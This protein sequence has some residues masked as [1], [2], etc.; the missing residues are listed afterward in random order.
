MI[1]YILGNRC[2]TC[3]N[4]NNTDSLICNL[5]F[6]EIKYIPELNFICESG[7]FYFDSVYSLL[8]YNY[9]LKKII[10]LYKFENIRS[11][12]SLLARLIL[13]R[14]K[15]EFFDEYD[16]IV[17]VPLHNKK[18]K[19]RGF[20]QTIKILQE[21]IENERIFTDIF[22]IR[23]TLQQSLLN[24]KKERKE[25]LKNI[26]EIKENRIKH[27]R[28]KKILLF[29]DIFTTGATL[30]AMAKPFFYSMV[31]KIDVLTVGVS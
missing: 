1:K 25:N 23:N 10:H 28:N 29:D 9:M 31:D 18:L 2:Y 3:N 14:Y 7:D 17:P 16:F 12:S 13:K 24:S 20:N 26:F 4:K 15:K 27:I 30:N 6:D 8:E 19:K 21:F 5:C 22:K 11:F